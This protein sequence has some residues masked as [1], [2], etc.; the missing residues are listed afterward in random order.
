LRTQ[1]EALLLKHLDKFYNKKDIPWVNMIWNS[2]YSQGQI[3][4]ATG[5]RGSFWWR[6]LL[7]LSD[8]FGGVASCIIGNGTSV[9]FW[10]DVWNGYYLQEKFPKL[11][12]FAKNKKNS[13][14]DFLSTGYGSSFSSS[15]LR[16]SLPGISRTKECNSGYTN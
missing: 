10:L 3:P 9:L 8:K 12:T 2:Y 16:T 13:V 15:P 6:D 14:A 4:H 7:H 1:N 5:D 11:F